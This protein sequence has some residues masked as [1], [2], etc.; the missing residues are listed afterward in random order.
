MSHVVD[1]NVALKG[2]LE[3]DSADMQAGLHRGG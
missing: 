3:A 1:P 2:V